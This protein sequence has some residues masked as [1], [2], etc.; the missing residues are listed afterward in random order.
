MRRQME[1]N[2]DLV[3]VSVAGSDALVRLLCKCNFAHACQINLLPTL[4]TAAEAGLV[5]RDLY[6]HQRHAGD[7]LRGSGLH[8]VSLPE[9][10]G[11]GKPPPDVFKPDDANELA[12]WADHP[13]HYDR[14]RNAKAR[15]IPSPRDERSTWLLF[16]DQEKIRAETTRLFYDV[17]LSLPE[18]APVRPE[19]VQAF[20]DE[21]HAAIRPAA[22]YR[23]IYDNRCLEITEELLVSEEATPV[24]DEPVEAAVA[25][26]Y[27]DDLASWVQDR[28]ARRADADLLDGIRT[29]R[30]KVP[31][32]IFEMGGQR[33]PV[34]SAATLLQN[35]QGR[36]EE[37]QQYLAGFDRNVF[38]LYLRLAAR[39]GKQ[40]ELR[41]KYQFHLRV[42]RLVRLAWEQKSRVESALVFFQAGHEVRWEEVSQIRDFLAQVHEWLIEIHRDAGELLLPPLTHVQSGAPA[43]TLLPPIAE[44]PDLTSA[45]SYAAL[46]LKQLA[47]FDRYVG[48]LAERLTAL[49]AK[50]LVAILNYQRELADPAR[51]VL[52]QQAARKEE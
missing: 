3:A 12:M 19:V 10:S 27:S 45:D 17:C 18:A 39:L 42:Q 9:P 15:Y 30:I 32:E 41:Q 5:S 6:L 34:A 1:L 11:D 28:R 20:I 26:L 44:L 2:A 38:A 4:A 22:C 40:A 43:A 14:E 13:S 50:S 31:G 51:C 37:D 23:G 48:I 36:L 29:G 35:R 24:G 25:T 47:A 49:Q 52:E 16:R 8:A 46:D 21:E 7:E 33:Y